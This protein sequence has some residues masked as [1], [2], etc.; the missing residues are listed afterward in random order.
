MPFKEKPYYQRFE[1]LISELG[2]E[3]AKLTE[4]KRFLLQEN[5]DLRGKLD[6]YKSENDSM[7]SHMSEG[8]KRALRGEIA[9][10]IRRVDKHISKQP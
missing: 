5:Q 10:L 7:F 8:E 2:D 3:L 6:Q 4:E 1:S 9:D